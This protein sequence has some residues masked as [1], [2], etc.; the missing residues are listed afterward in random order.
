MERSA[1]FPR[2]HG[3]YRACLAVGLSAG[4]LVSKLFTKSFAPLLM[5]SQHFLL[6]SSLPVRMEALQV[7][8]ML[9]ES[10]RN[11]CLTLMEEKL[12][13][14]CDA[15]KHSNGSGDITLI[16][17][18]ICRFREQQI[19]SNMLQA[20][21]HSYLGCQAHQILATDGLKGFDLS[22]K[23]NWPVSI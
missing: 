21:A 17:N 23:G 7:P 13:C 19:I 22:S 2:I 15:K 5:P 3:W 8:Y 11:A 12:I 9:M 20:Q 14:C 10:P 6:K 4:S 18:S 1:T 16:D